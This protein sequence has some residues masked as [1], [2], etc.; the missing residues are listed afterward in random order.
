MK[1]YVKLYLTQLFLE[2]EVF[3]KNLGQNLKYTVYVQ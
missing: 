2:W 3:R 1:S